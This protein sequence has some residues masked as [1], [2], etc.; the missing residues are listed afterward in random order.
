MPIFDFANTQFFASLLTIIMIDLVLAGDNSIVIAMAVQS[1][2]PKKRIKGI[3][4]G[5][6][7]AVILRVIFT[8]FASKLLLHPYVKLVGGILILWIAVKMMI[9][10]CGNDK[11]CKAA[12]SIWSAVWII[13]IADVTMSLDNILA[14]AGASHGSLELLIF[15]LGLSIPLVVFASSLISRLLEK[16][17]AIM[18][19][20]AVILG[21][22]GGEMVI[23][24]P[25]ILKNIFIPAGLTEIRHGV[26][27]VLH[28]YVWIA[29]GAG[30]VG[31][32][33]ASLLFRKFNL[34]K[35]K[36]VKV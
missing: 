12:T 1:L 3:I 26:T 9:D 11:H 30:A 13:L 35:K 4:F 27:A 15:G 29:E 32:L 2:E 14:V 31:V 33:A 25:V 20:G 16:Y 36:T 5:A 10:S 22:V 17:P 28:W 34:F 7:A 18:W 23:T 21:K 6:L 24:D 19:I 8:F